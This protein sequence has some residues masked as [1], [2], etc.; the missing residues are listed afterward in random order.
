MTES[1]SIRVAV[2]LSGGLDSAVVASLLVEQGLDVVGLTLN[3]FKEGSR[4]CSIDDIQRSQRV[5]DHLG[6]THSAVNVV[7]YFEEA[8]IQPFVEDYASGRTPSPCVLCNQYVKFGALHRRAMQ[9]GCSHVATGHYVHNEHRADGWHL[10]RAEDAKKDQSYFLH[11][12]SQDQLARSLFP[13]ASWSK[14]QVAAYAEER[15]LPVSTSSKAESQD[16]CFVSDAGHTSFIEQFRPDLKKAGAIV[17]SQGALLGQHQGFHQ[18]TVG[19]RKGLGVAAKERLY[20]KKLHADRNEVVLAPRGE[21]F[22]STCKVQDMH[23][24]SGQTPTTPFDSTARIRYR[25]KATPCRVVLLQDHE[26]K[27]VFE[28]AQFAVTPGQAAVLYHG[29]EVLGG[30]WIAANEKEQP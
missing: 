4:C 27:V 13:L 2:G 3:M 8:I 14:P 17:D 29:N 21:L 28:E 1:S 20:V 10:F 25:H 22:T 5:C 11:R 16:L 30:G 19:Q 7:E 18:F 26:I 9:L 15:G 24:I 12:L 6:I 23:W